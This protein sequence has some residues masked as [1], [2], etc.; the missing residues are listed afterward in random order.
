MIAG[1][2]LPFSGVG[3]LPSI[4]QTLIANGYTVDKYMEAKGNVESFMSMRGN[5]AVQRALGYAGR[6]HADE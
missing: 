5:R 3:S 6:F 2:S 4:E 1:F